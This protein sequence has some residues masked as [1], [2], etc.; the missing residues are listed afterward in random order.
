MAILKVIYFTSGA[1]IFSILATGILRRYSLSHSLLDIPNERSS[2]TSPTP[3]GGGL[4]IALAVLIT[5]AFLYFLHFLPFAVAIALGG[6]GILVSVTGW[7][8][9]HY[10]IPEIWKALC[11]VTAAVWAVYWMGGIDTLWLGE[12]VITLNLAGSLLAV[13]GCA[14]LINLYNF[15][16]GTDALAAVQAICTGTFSGFLLMTLGRQDL[17]ILCFV[18]STA[19]I[20]FLYWNWPPARIFMGDVG[21][22]FIGFSFGVLAI[23]G[24][25]SGVMPALVWFILLSV[26]ICDATLTLFWR[27]LKKEKWYSAHR[28]HAYQRVV[29]MGASHANLAVCVLL[30]NVTFLWPMAYIAWRWQQFTLTVFATTVLIMCLLWSIIQWR[31]ISIATNNK[32]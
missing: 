8:D 3:R 18:I 19:A 5:A 2:H 15:M 22:C 25:K 27:I 7:L 4:A 13:L 32:V 24:E 31:F 14:W 17:A 26:F 11:Y 21:S 1:L 28:S 12:T 10:D 29:Q 20:G 6:G 16:D 9:D 23:I 30:I